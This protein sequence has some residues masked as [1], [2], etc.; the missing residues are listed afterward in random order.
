MPEIL[1]T[2]HPEIAEDAPYSGPEIVEPPRALLLLPLGGADVRRA[3]ATGAFA[4]ALA[5]AGVFTALSMHRSDEVKPYGPALSLNRPLTNGDCVHVKWPGTPFT[6]E[7]ELKIVKCLSGKT[8]GQVMTTVMA[9]TAAQARSA[10]P[11]QCERQTEGTRAKL[12]D[13]RSY[14]VVPTRA[15]FEA[16]GRRTA[17]LILDAR[18][19][20][21][22]GPIGKY[23]PLGMLFKDTVTMQKR[24]CL[25]RVSHNAARLIPCTGPHDEQVLG[26]HRMSA[27]TTHA[28]AREQAT[29]ACQ[30]HMPPSDYGYDPT[31][32]TSSSWVGSSS[33]NTG[34]HFVVC[35]V[36]RKDG[37]TMTKN[38]P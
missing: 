13:V 3:V 4:L 17:C 36:T 1:P 32:Y 27:D 31:L 33:W 16:A 21:L 14:A 12:A 28:Q 22:Y 34:A 11:G 15:G 29:E 8:Y 5:L 30:E 19:A 7:P 26:F 20:P 25:S 6:G 35:T 23:R 18:G 37:G 9:A 24:D 10:G 38:E 2:S